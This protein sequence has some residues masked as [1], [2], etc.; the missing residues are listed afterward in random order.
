MSRE[1]PYTESGERCMSDES[2]HKGHRD[3]IR[4]RFVLNGADSLFDHELLELLLFYAIPRRNTNEIAHN[5]IKMFGDLEGVLNASPE[6]MKKVKGV[7][8][9]VSTFIVL[10]RQMS[11]E[12]GLTAPV[13]R[14]AATYEN[15]SSYFYDYFSD[16]AEGLCVV[17]CP[18]N[19]TR[20]MAFR[21]KL[22]SSENE[23]RAIVES[24]VIRQCDTV[25]IGINHG[26]GTLAP[27]NDDFGV[28]RLFSQK[29]A[30]L[31]I[32]VADCIIVNNT[33]TFSLKCDGAFR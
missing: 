16:V 26:N 30:L 3:R 24:V 11:E 5:L 15:I 21:D 2:C 9:A 10:M 1:L 4:R 8:D 33:G 29:F 6:E 17:Y 27:C 7:G 32:T 18:D 31:E 19:N 28:M 22:L 14:M 20:F 25:F 12:Y 23:S 13:R